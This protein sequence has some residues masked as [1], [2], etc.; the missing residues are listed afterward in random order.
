MLDPEFHTSAVYGFPVPDLRVFNAHRHLM[1]D[2]LVFEFH[3]MRTRT[4]S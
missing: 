3:L 4:V 2:R 1:R